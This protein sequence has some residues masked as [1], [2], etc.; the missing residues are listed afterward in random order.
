MFGGPGL[1]SGTG[2]GVDGDDE[3]GLELGVEELDEEDLEESDES[4]FRL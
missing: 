2:E 1:V 4:S 3:E